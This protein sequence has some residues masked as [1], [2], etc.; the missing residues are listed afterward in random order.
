M[1]AR[2]VQQYEFY[3][4]NQIS[5]KTGGGNRGVVKGPNGISYL[6]NFD[7][8]ALGGFTSI[9]LSSGYKINSMLSAGVNITNLFNTDQREFAGSPLIRRL[10]MCELKV[11]VPNT[12]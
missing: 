3:S 12:K 7:W 5:T 6:K 2:Y 8:G 9:D 1:S 11:R 4:G 10:I